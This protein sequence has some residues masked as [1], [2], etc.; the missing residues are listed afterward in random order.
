MGIS[1][2]ELKNR[3]SPII[4]PPLPTPPPHSTYT[5]PHITED[6]MLRNTYL[7]ENR[8]FTNKVKPSIIYGL[9]GKSL[10]EEEK[11]VSTN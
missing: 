2:R 6:R 1:N 5:L 10:R 7:Y 11:S 4:M 8:M 3:A 9:K